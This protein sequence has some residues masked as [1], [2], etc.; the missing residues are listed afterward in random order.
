MT[1]DDL[2]IQWHLNALR[3]N[4]KFLLMVYK[5][6]QDPLSYFSKVNSGHSPPLLLLFLES[7]TFCSCLL[8]ANEPLIFFWSYLNVISSER[9]SLIL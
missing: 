2:T 8:L 4:F 3:I 5:G 1:L 6:L 7:G 9:L